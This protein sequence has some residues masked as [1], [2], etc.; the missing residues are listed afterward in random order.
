MRPEP[1]ATATVERARAMGLEAI[2]IPLFKTEPVPWIAPAADRFD[3]LLLTSANAV[4]HGGDELRKLRH[5]PVYVVGAATAQAARNHGF[6]I[7][8]VGNGGVNAL[9]ESV[10]SSRLKFLHLCGEDRKAPTVMAHEITAIVTY[11]A[12]EIPEPELSSAPDDIALI[13]S[14]RA[15]RRLAELIEDRSDVVVAAISPAAAQAVGS[16][17][18]AVETADEPNDDALLALAAR[19]CNKP[20]TE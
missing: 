5:L 17:W 8:E 2:A 7:A 1:G 16:G 10:P 15:S 9:L 19:L 6:T 11:R 12:I 20:A 13:H 4:R 3:A 14:P 18:R